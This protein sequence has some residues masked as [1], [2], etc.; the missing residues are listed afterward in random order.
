MMDEAPS[1]ASPAPTVETAAEDQAE[2]PQPRMSDHCTNDNPLDTS[3][4]ATGEIVKLADVDIY[5]S[6]PADVASGTARLVLLLTGGTGIMA[7]TNRI[8]ADHFAQEGYFV[9]MPDLFNGDSAPNA[10]AVTAHTE[11]AD[12]LETIKFKAA[13]GVKGFMIDMWLARHTPENTMPII[14]KVLRAV[15]ETYADT[16]YDA[17]MGVLAVGY[18]FG[19]KYVLR[20]AATDEI[21]AGVAAHGLLISKEDI[22]GVKKPVTLACVENDIFFPDEVRDEGRKQLQDNSIDHELRVYPG[23]PHGFAVYGSYSEE[24]IKT[25]QRQAFDQFLEF[26]NKY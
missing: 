16:A 13:E 20:L 18:C 5:V 7:K 10:A 23:V 25:A 26:L 21:V 9:V 8:Q 6:K 24:H 17:S 4:V 2:A 12:L 15:R 1:K 11:N 3:E 22:A 19:A 14:E